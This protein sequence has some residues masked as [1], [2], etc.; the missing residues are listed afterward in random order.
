MI[1]P[2]IASRRR[3]TLALVSLLALA[4]VGCGDDD[5]QAPP[6]PEAELTEF[7]RANYMLEAM[8]AEISYPADNPPVEERIE[9]GRLLFFDPILSG[10]EDVSC[11]HCHHPT[12]AWGDGRST[13]IGVGGEGLGPDRVRTIGDEPTEFFT[14]RNTPSCLDTAFNTPF[15]GDPDWDGR[16]FWDGRETSLE[17]QARA[18]LRSRDEMRHD[19]YGGPEAVTRVVQRLQAIPE[20][21]TGFAE[22]FPEDYQAIVNEY[23]PDFDHFVIN[24]N[25]YSRAV[26]AY[27]RELCTADSPFDQFVR[28]DDAALTYQQ[29]RGL[30]VF[31]RSGCGDCHSGPMFSDF[32]FKV[33]GVLQG[34]AGKPPIHEHGDGT[35]FGRYLQ[36]GDD[37]DRHAFRTPTLRNIALTGPYFH[38]GGEEAGGDYQTLRQ[39]VEFYNRGGNDEGLELMR[40]DP[41]VRPLGLTEDEI[42]DMVAFMESLT[43]ERLVS[44]LVDPTVPLT[45]PSGLDPPDPLTG[46]VLTY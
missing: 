41:D 4:V 8:P 6:D 14:P 18:P 12:F 35:D 17:A 29:K 43:G 10:D 31:M 16:M 21:V 30:D 7:I 1:R 46:P 15:T 26:A 37:A 32:E 33:T 3:W 5:T 13:S 19:A 42:D 11:G 36:T 28:G 34:G 39:V 23:G 27:E 45:V 38:T 25:T 20:Y 40:I 22:A 44:D 2:S 9:L 24:G